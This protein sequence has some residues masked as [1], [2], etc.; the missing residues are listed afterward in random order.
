MHSKSQ[1]RYH[2]LDWLRIFAFMLLIFYH[3]GRAFFPEDPWHINDPEGSWTLRIGMD[4][5]ARW[6]L[7]LLFFVSGLASAFVLASRNIPLFLSNRALRLLLPLVFAMAVI[8]PPQVWI[9]RVFSGQT[10]LG[11][12]AWYIQDAFTK[13]TYSEGNISWHHLWYIAYLFVMT[14]MLLPL[15]AAYQRGK[16]AWFEDQIKWL[17]SGPQVLAFV[18]FPLFI[19]GTIGQIWPGR[20]NALLDDWGWL[21]LC[22]TW[23]LIGFFIKPVMEEFTSTAQ[24]IYLFC[25]ALWA[26]MM[27]IIL[28]APGSDDFQFSFGGAMMR[29]DDALSLPIGWIAIVTL[30]G[31][32]SKYFN[33]DAPL[34]S[35][36]N[37]AV[38]PLYIV[39]Q[40]IAIG[41]VFLIIP[42]Q[43]SVWAK[44]GLAVLFTFGLSFALHHFVLLKLGKFRAL[45]GIAH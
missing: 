18:L 33:R 35:Y 11:Y 17:V 28:F 21:A 15:L 39:H 19:R 26:G 32:F 14:L 22:S 34:K 7:P 8:V 16:L 31:L 36:L 27:A 40:T 9:E 44:F 41:A 38:Y 12:F 30:V 37:R 25:S 43:I 4:L 6:R 2:Y 23:F 24:K 45:F 29:F 10:Q 1:T 20:S 13:G 42:L 3:A 5:V